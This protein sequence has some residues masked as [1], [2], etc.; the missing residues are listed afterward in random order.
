MAFLSIAIFLI[1]ETRVSLGRV[2][3]RSYNVL[4]SICAV[5]TAYSSIPAILTYLIK[6]ETIA[7]SIQQSTL[8][9]AALIFSACRLI[10]TAKLDTGSPSGFVLAINSDEN[11][12]KE[13]DEAL[14]VSKED[15]A[16][17]SIEDIEEEPER[18][19]EA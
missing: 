13:N 3:W 4:A 8:L 2:S 1:T 15:L 7:I 11:A 5:L 9:L 19:G 6:G 17:I 16:Q 10:H 18:H 14:A 12:N